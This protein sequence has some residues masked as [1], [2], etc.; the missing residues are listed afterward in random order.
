[1][2]VRSHRCALGAQEE[3]VE[4]NPTLQGNEGG[5]AIGNGGDKVLMKTLDSFGFEKISFIKIDVE[6]HEDFV[7]EGGR[8]TIRRC[9]PVMLVEIM[10]GH[11]RDSCPKPVKKKIKRTIKKIEKLGYRVKQ[12]GRSCDYLATPK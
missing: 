7:L 8:E 12:I 11:Y 5:T 6:H 3:A 10:G 1:M 4:M 2:L 9:R